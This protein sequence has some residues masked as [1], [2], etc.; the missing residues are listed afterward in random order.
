MMSFTTKQSK[1]DAPETIIHTLSN[2]QYLT[3]VWDDGS[4]CEIWFEE[5]RIVY[6]SNC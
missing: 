2:S 1:A 3:Q 5:D 6:E 4:D